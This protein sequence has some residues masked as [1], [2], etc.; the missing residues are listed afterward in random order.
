MMHVGHL[1]QAGASARQ[2]AGVGWR[3]QTR[4]LP[5]VAD[6]GAQAPQGTIPHLSLSEATGASAGLLVHFQTSNA[7]SAPVLIGAG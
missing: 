5:W 6:E 1:A 7:A 2:Q 4:W 3:Q